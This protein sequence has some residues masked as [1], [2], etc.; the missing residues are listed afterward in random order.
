[1]Q[2]GEQAAV[3][4]GADLAGVDERVVLE[5]S[6][7][8]R[9]DRASPVRRQREAADHHLLGE[10]ALRLAPVSAAPLAIGRVRALAH[11]AL[12]PGFARLLEEL[13]A[14]P[15]HV[16]AEAQRVGRCLE[17]APQHL[18]A[19]LEPHAAE[20]PAVE[21][22]QVEGEVDERHGC[23]AAALE[24]LEARRAVRQHGGHLAVDERRP[25]RQPAHGARDLRKLLGP[26]LPVARDEPHLALLD[27]GHDAV[28]VVLDLVEPLVARRRRLDD[29]RE[30]ERLGLL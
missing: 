25:G 24:R 3:E 6:D 8:Q 30:R 2:V 13:G 10:P 19:L 15:A 4:A 12:E 11:H 27:A 26:V 21:V 16:I 14:V 20:V 5:E 22:Q 1:M 18:L 7:E 17:E 29:H 28:A 9:P 23:V